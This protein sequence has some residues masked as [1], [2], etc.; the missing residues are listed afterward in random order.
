MQFAQLLGYAVERYAE[1]SYVSSESIASA[2]AIMDLLPKRRSDAPSAFDER[3]A[4]GHPEQPTIAT[5]A[6]RRFQANAL[7]AWLHQKKVFDFTS[8]LADQTF[9][10][11]DKVQV[12]QL[13]GHSIEEVADIVATLRRTERSN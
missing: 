8:V 5:S 2:S 7:I 9:A 6:G 10:R 13:L 4:L 12:A 3:S 11:E 1:V